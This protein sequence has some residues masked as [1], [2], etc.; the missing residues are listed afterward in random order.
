MA[1]RVSEQTREELTPKSKSREDIGLRRQDMEIIG[2]GD[3]FHFIVVKVT[4]RMFNLDGVT[5]HASS[6]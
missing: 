1:Q 2:S 3:L 6:L 5:I 4:E